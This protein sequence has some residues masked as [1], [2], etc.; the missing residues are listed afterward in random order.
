MQIKL[1]FKPSQHLFLVQFNVASYQE[2]FASLGH[3]DCF[4]QQLE[5]VTLVFYFYHRKDATNI[6]LYQHCFQQII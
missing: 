3:P 5:V 4:Q 1:Y 6:R 2:Y